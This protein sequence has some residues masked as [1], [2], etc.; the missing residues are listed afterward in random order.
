LGLDESGRFRSLNGKDSSLADHLAVIPLVA[1]TTSE[2]DLLTGPPA[3]RRRFLDRGLIAERPAF[4]G[5]FQRY[6]QALAQ[7]RALLASR[8]RDLDSWNDLLARA[9]H[10]VARQRATHVGR[11]AKALARVLGRAEFPFPP[12]EIHYR[13]SPATALEGEV[14][15]RRAFERAAAEEMRRRQPLVGPHRDDVVVRWGETDLRRAASA[16]ERKA[17]GLALLV[18]Q[19]EVL[20]AAGRR[21]TLLLDDADTELDRHA[22]GRVWRLVGER[23]VLA[24][25]NR[26]EAW[27]GLDV[28]GRFELQNG[29]LS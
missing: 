19:V 1:W 5:V 21:P 11:V 25:S 26:A 2:R 17:L 14:E 28:E 22:L 7:K 24:S 6:A 12:I 27:A 15:L 16:G 23:S 13:P 18:A 20:E 8:K 3:D 29:E 10:E 9:G 4:L